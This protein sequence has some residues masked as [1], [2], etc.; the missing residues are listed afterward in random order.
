M[1]FIYLWGL[2]CELRSKYL[3]VAEEQTDLRHR[4][5]ASVKGDLLGERELVT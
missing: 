5:C 2:L 4:G 3:Y 1:I